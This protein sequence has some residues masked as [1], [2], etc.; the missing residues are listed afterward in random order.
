MIKVQFWRHQELTCK[1]NH[2]SLHRRVE[3]GVD[4]S[5]NP[6]RRDGRVPEELLRSKPPKREQREGRELKRPWSVLF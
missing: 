4:G 5:Q 1:S 6:P 2:A 3:L